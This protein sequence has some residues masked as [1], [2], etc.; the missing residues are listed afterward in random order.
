MVPEVWGEKRKGRIEAGGIEGHVEATDEDRG[1]WY[2]FM[3]GKRE[4]RREGV[5]S[6]EERNEFFR[7]DRSP[8][9]SSDG[10][11]K[12]MM[13]WH[14]MACEVSDSEESVETS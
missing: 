4:G 9:D 5:D 13:A 11:F 7:L 3:D 2:G 14:S 10:D 8:D 1:Y 12:R 6:V